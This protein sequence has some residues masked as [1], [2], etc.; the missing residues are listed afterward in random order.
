MSWPR[1][2]LTAEETKYNL[3]Y[4]DPRK[5]Q[6]M[7]LRRIYYGSLQISSSKR[8]DTLAYQ[9]SRR[10]R[11]VALTVAGDVD[12]FLMEIQDVSGEQYTTGP[13]HVPLLVGGWI[14]DPLSETAVSTV[15]PP[16][17]IGPP[18][19]GPYVF[20]PNIVVRPNQTIQ[21]ITTP[22]LQSDTTNTYLLG[23]CLHVVEFPGMPGSPL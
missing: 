21:I 8:T 2:Q 1:F 11:I 13:I 3:K 6:N 23:V 17:I 15:T 5:P 7:V 14:Q 19:M 4:E 16:V 20:E 22:A 9:I 18:T 12:K 10:S